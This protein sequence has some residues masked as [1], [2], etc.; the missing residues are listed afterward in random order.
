MRPEF[1]R[2]LAAELGDQRGLA[3]AIRPNDRV[4]FAGRHIEH[5]IVGGNDALEAL[6]QILHLQQRF[7]HGLPLGLTFA[8][9]FDSS[10]SMPPR[11]NST[12]SSSSGPRTICQNSP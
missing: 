5:E 3:G 1:G 7:A 10:P 6:G 2:Q 12:T 8:L 4:Q 11:A 9:T